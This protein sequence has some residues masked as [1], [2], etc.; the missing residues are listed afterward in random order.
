MNTVEDLV[1]MSEYVSRAYVYNRMLTRATVTSECKHK[2][3]RFH[4]NYGGLYLSE[5]NSRFFIELGLMKKE[6]VQKRYANFLFVM[7]TFF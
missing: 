4:W 6:I 5:N 1:P 7:H 3:H 2:K